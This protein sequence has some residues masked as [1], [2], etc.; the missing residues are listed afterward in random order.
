[1]KQNEHKISAVKVYKA[2]AT[3]NAYWP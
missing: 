2:A 3:P 1:M